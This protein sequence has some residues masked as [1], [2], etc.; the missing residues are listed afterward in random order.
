M[1]PIQKTIFSLNKNFM[2][3]EPNVK[4]KRNYEFIEDNLPVEKIQHWDYLKGNYPDTLIFLRTSD[5]YFCL[6]LDAET[7]G[8]IMNS[9]NEK[10]G[11]RTLHRFNYYSLDD[12]LTKMV[13]AGYKIAV[14]DQLEDPGKILFT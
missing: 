2:I 1:I 8:G 7:V 14:C 5:F 4:T 6:D 9:E 11:T 12:Y 13:K 3:R 10:E